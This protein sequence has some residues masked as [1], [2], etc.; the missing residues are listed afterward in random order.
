MLD[1]RVPC[2]LIY[3]YSS[4]TLLLCSPTRTQCTYTY[5]HSLC[6]T[7]SDCAIA[8]MLMDVAWCFVWTLKPESSSQVEDTVQDG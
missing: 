1:Y 6:V 2:I 7:D 4:W 3:V 5:K 8:V